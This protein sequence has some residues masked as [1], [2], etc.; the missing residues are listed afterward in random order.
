MAAK[1]QPIETKRRIPR[2]ARAEETVAAILEGAAQILEAGG[3]AA[4]TTNAVAERAGV[5]I[6]TLY[7]YFG[8]KG[9]L[10]RSLGEREMRAALGAI[11]RAMDREAQPVERER[12]V[13]R[14]IINAFHGRQRARKAVL[15]AVLSQGVAIELLGPVATFLAEASRRHEAMVPRGMA[16]LTPE[17][18]FVLTRAIM[19][20]IRAAVLEEQ[21]FLKSQKFEDEVVRLAMS[22]LRAVAAAA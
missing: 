12:A 21:P 17:Q 7:Q 2:Q 11:G 9:A 20:A 5:S 1:R 16:A 19:G 10:L 3:L 6:G 4:F 15:Q 14:A 22:Y 13:I 18:L 8:D